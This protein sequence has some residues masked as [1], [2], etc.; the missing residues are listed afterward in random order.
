MSKFNFTKTITHMFKDYGEF[1]IDVTDEYFDGKDV[2]LVLTWEET[3]KCLID[4]LASAD[5][6]PYDIE[7][8]YP[9]SADYDKEYIISLCHELAD[10]KDVA[11]VERAF[12]DLGNFTPI[13]SYR[14]DR[15]TTVFV[16]QDVD[17]DLYD[18][19]AKNDYNIVLFD[20]N[21]QRNCRC[22]SHK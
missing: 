7:F 12:N 14:A 21:K 1:L 18:A 6:L 13:G 4:V 19:Y 5:V 16:S 22:V 10:G 20:I 2:L 17:R 15:S 8:G 3:A 9:N 11:L